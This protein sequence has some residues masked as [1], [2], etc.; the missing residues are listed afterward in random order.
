MGRTSVEDRIMN[1][2]DG[3]LS[4]IALCL[5]TGWAIGTFVVVAWMCGYRLGPQ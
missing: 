2:V 5:F 1:V 3:L 4:L